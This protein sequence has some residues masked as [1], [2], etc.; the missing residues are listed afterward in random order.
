MVFIAATSDFFL[1]N[2]SF[3]AHDLILV[4]IGHLLDS[5]ETNIFEN[6]CISTSCAKYS[7]GVFGVYR[8]RKYCSGGYFSVIIGTYRKHGTLYGGHISGSNA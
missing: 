2:Q 7:F 8:F 5:L 3:L 6:T 1:S 4:L